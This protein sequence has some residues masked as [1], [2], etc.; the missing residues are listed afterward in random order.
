[1]KET[2]DL[3]EE[4]FQVP[5]RDEVGAK[6]MEKKFKALLKDLVG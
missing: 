5:D 3:S 1:M 6:K 2:E 4:L